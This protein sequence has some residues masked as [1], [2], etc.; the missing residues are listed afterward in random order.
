MERLRGPSD[1]QLSTFS[2]ALARSPLVYASY[3][4]VCNNLTTGNGEKNNGQ[5]MAIATK[6]S[7]GDAPSSFKIWRGYS[8]GNHVSTTER[9][10]TDR[11]GG[12]DVSI[13]RNPPR[14]AT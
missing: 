1:G 4:L 13:K 3:A 7:A 2:A 11:L 14:S 9:K 10:K 5:D 8:I 12:V 6:L